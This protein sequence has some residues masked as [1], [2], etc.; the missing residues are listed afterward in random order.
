MLLRM[1][2][3]NDTA[4]HGIARERPRQTDVSDVARARGKA[5]LNCIMKFTLSR[6]EKRA[7]PQPARPPPHGLFWETRGGRA[8]GS[9]PCGFHQH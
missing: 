5:R 7:Q 4:S 2:M 3:R 6:C 1:A 9:R 8:W